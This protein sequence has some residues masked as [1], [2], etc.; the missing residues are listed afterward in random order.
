MR[1]S[2]STLFDH[3]VGP[4]EQRWRNLEAERPGGLEVNKHLELGGLLNR[5]LGW[6]CTLEKLIDVGSSAPDQISDICSVG[7]ETADIYE[8]SNSIERRQSLR[9]HELHN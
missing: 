9:G 3:L 6:F 5:K 8:F 2:K 4:R 7:D 1:C